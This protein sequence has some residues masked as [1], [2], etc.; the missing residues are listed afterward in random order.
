MPKHQKKAAFIAEME[1]SH[2]ALTDCLSKLGDADWLK[3]NTCGE[4]SIKDVVAHITDW[5]TRCNEWYLAGKRGEMPKTPDPDFEWGQIDPINQSI[6][7]KHR[8]EPLQQVRN[9]FQASWQRTLD[10]VK[11]ITEDEL[12]KPNQFA[13]LYDHILADVVADNTTTHYR[14]HLE[15][16]QAWLDSRS[17]G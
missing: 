7:E 10:S 11:S 16:I 1:E 12:F 15:S 17:M 2:Q 4:W 3:A 6:H 14:K 13:W 5:E 9:E 8:D